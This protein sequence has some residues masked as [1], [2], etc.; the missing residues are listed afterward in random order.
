MSQKLYLR[1]LQAGVCLS[2]FIVFWVN[3]DFLFPYITSKQIPFNIL[4]EVLFVIWL[5]FIVKYKEYRPK[6]SYIT[7]GLAFFFGV[8]I[9]SCFTGVDFNLSFWGDVERMLGAFHIL[10]FFILY[11][12][13]IT[14]FRK[15]SDWRILY[16]LSIVVAVFVSF[17]GFPD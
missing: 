5:T 9:L 11:L 16:I 13:I 3:K 4:M 17:K 7:F 6:L 1:I 12:V 10:H 14:V 2:F 8:M 15:W